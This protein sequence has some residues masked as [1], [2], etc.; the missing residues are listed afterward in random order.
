MYLIS[1]NNITDP[2]MNLALEEYCL[3]H[4]GSDDDYVLLY[5]NEPSIIVGRFQNALE[6][7]NQEYVTAKGLHVIRRMSGGGAVYHDHGNL[8]FSFM[9][10]YAKDRLCNFRLFTEPVIRTLKDMGVHAELTGR[11]DILVNGKKISGNAQYVTRHAM[12]T[13]GTLLF[14]ADMEALVR[15]LNVSQDKIVSKALQSVRSR[16]TTIRECT[17]QA[18]DME[19]FRSR[20]LANLFAQDG[21][22]PSYALTH[23]QWEEVTDLAVSKYGSWAWN[24]GKS[25]RYNVQRKHRFPI[26]QVDTR[27]QVE[28]GVVRRVKIYGDFLGHGEIHELEALLTGKAFRRDVL[29]TCLQE[30]DLSMYFGEMPTEDFVTYLWGDTRDAQKGVG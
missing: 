20:L 6:E 25:P 16:V 4:L 9:T 10:R 24:F 21:G 7:I 11:N 8:N 29:E 23:E 26:G 18:G 17:P 30:V 12:L 5:V 13:H 19:A 15:A 2:R 22:V 3:R 27:M 28:G 14:D 1:N